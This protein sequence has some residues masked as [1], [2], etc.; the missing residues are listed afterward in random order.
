MFFITASLAYLPGLTD[1]DGYTFGVFKL[2]FIDDLLHSASGLWAAIAAWRSTH[3]SVIYFKIF[4]IMYSLDGVMGLITG[5]GYLD[6]GIFLNEITPISI[7]VRIA[8]NLPH[9]LIGGIALYV[10][11]V[12]S[13]QFMENTT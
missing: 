3:A 4:G 9:I 13:R 5:L 7:G 12:M 11:F 10:G 8:A 2:D 1:A 6:G